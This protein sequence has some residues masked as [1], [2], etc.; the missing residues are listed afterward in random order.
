MTVVSHIPLMEIAVSI[1]NTCRVRQ[2]LAVA[3]RSMAGKLML[4][5]LASDWIRLIRPAAEILANIVGPDVKADLAV[6]LRHRRAHKPYRRQPRPHL[7][8]V[9][10]EHAASPTSFSVRDQ[11]L[12]AAA[13]LLAIV[14]V[15]STIVPIS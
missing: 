5:E 10:M 12:V 3:A 13:L 7:Q 15:I 2:S 14:E 9:R 11:N 6:L 1:L 4:M 8:L